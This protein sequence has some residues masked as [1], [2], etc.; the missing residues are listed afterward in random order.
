MVKDVVVDL[1][2]DASCDVARDYALSLSEVFDAHLCGVVLVREYPVWVAST[3]VET[4][5]ITKRAAAR[6][7]EA[8]KAL[9]EFEERVRQHGVHW[10]TSVISDSFGDP[11]DLFSQYARN[12]DLS[13]VPQSESEDDTDNESLV[14]AALFESGRPVLVVPFI[15]NGGMKLNRVL[16]CWD[17][18]RSAARAVGDAAPFLR[19]ANKVEVITVENKERPRELNGIAIAEHLARRGINLEL[20]P[21]VAPYTNVADVILNEVAETG[22]DLIVMG[23]YSHSRLRETVLGGV[24]RSILKSMTAPV[25]MAH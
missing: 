12:Y 7:A 4:A 14:T 16:V 22:V 5:V 25:L 23:A 10:S 13:V 17:G 6:H 8:E 11:A 20:R 9:R 1:S 24:T 19:R 15:Q 18:S 3:G 21:L 2:V